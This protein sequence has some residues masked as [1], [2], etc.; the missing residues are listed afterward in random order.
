M[1]DENYGG[2]SQI[3]MPC[4]NNYSTIT[5]SSLLPV[6]SKKRPHSEDLEATKPKKFKKSAK[7]IPQKLA[8]EQFI[9]EVKS[10]FGNISVPQRNTIQIKSY[11]LLIKILQNDVEISYHYGSNK[12]ISPIRCDFSSAIKAIGIIK[13][14]HA[15]Y[16]KAKEQA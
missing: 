15:E 16:K 13:N 5:L 10:L 7:E 14:K 9:S 1:I 4:E 3:K 2:S 12:P 6:A 11:D 8:K